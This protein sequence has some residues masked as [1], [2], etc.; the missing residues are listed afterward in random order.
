MCSVAWP[1]ESSDGFCFP[2]E[3]CHP[4]KTCCAFEKYL[5]NST[6][7]CAH[8][9]FYLLDVILCGGKDETLASVS[10]SRPFLKAG[11]ASR[12][13]RAAVGSQAEHSSWTSPSPPAG[14]AFIPGRIRREAINKL[15]L[16]LPLTEGTPG[17]HQPVWDQLFPGLW[18]PV[19]AP[20]ASAWAQIRALSCWRVLWGPL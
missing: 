14:Q 17:W 9:W 10:S 19:W 4:K 16:H 2:R 7:N 15:G 6:W 12:L 8:C 13:L 3:Q 1:M 11:R 5:N 18:S 20:W